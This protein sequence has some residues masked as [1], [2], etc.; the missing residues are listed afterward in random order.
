MGPRGLGRA[1]RSG[2]GPPIAPTIIKININEHTIM[3]NLELKHP[4]AFP[5]T[6]YMFF[7]GC[8][9]LFITPPGCTPI[10]LTLINISKTR[11]N[12]LTRIQKFK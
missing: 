9:D 7:K 11:V 6:F 12:E 3:K 2:G 4:P 10:V 5:L 8:K 1:W